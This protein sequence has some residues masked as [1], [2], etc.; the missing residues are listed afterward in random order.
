MYVL[1][2]FACSQQETE[3]KTTDVVY[4]QSE[5]RNMQFSF[6]TPTTYFTLAITSTFH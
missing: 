6:N 4:S 3:H 1:I 2:M 5:I